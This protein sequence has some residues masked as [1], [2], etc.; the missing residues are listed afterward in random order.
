MVIKDYVTIL[1]TWLFPALKA[2]GVHILRARMYEPM[3]CGAL[4][5][6]RESVDTRPHVSTRGEKRLIPRCGA[7]A[8]RISWSRP[9]R[10]LEGMWDSVT[11]PCSGFSNFEWNWSIC[12]LGRMII[13]HVVILTFYLPNCPPY[14]LLTS[15]VVVSNGGEW[16]WWGHRHIRT[17]IVGAVCDQKPCIVQGKANWE[18]CPLYWHWVQQKFLLMTSMKTI[19]PKRK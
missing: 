12:L 10:C 5:H 13:R 14:I 17:K 4:L 8:Q 6:V 7:H 16:R 3:F 19:K 1:V 9:A 15:L 18:I 11:W 2:G